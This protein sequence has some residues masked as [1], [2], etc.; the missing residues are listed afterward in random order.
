MKFDF[1]FE[2][3]F[4]SHRVEKHGIT[5]IIVKCQHIDIQFASPRSCGDIQWRVHIRNDIKKR[6]N[7]LHLSDGTNSL[8]ECNLFS[9]HFFF[10][11]RIMS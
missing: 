11:D 10:S 4:F 1:I 5:T 8:F 6:V 9:L 7:G 3:Y 2:I